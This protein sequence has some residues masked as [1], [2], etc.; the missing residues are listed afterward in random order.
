M[1]HDATPTK[2]AQHIDQ[3]LQQL[4]PD[5][6]RYQVL[7]SAK[8]FKS[9]WAE[10]GESL[11]RV[12]NTGEFHDWGYASFEDYCAREIRIRRVQQPRPTE[13]LPHELPSQEVVPPVGRG[14]GEGLL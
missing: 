4:S 12:A 5:S 10:L 7:M 11:T 14:L 6:E 3:L 1:D 2:G 13:G 9:S 8:R